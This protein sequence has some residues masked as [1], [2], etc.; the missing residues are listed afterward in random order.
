MKDL[1][2][3]LVVWYL[4]FIIFFII[5][6]LTKKTEAPSFGHHNN[7][8]GSGGTGDSPFLAE[9][10]LISSVRPFNLV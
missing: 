10:N 1:Y 9:S 6:S 5:K 3:T 4:N 7:C 8:L 2:L